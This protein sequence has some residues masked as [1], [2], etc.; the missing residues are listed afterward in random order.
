MKQ[1]I[2]ER[3][4]KI[5]NGEVP[6]GYRKTKVGIIPD[7]WTLDNL[8]IHVSSFIVPMR[9]K[10]KIF[11]G[12]IPWC[13]IED[14]QGKYLEKSLSNQN[15]SKETIDEMN[16]RV[17]P[18]GTVLCSCSARLGI[19][20]IVRKPL[21]TN[22]T[23]IG[24]VP[25]EE[26]DNEFLYYFMGFKCEKLQ[27][28]SSG[29]TISYLSRE[30]FEN[31]PITYTTLKEQKKIIS[32]IS[33]W[34][35]AIELKEKLIEEKKE[36]KKGLMQKLLTGKIR[37]PEFTDEWM[38]IDL[39][40]IV[41]KINNKNDEKNQTIVT[42]SAKKGFVNQ[43]EYFNKI[44]ASQDLS[45]YYLIRK[46]DFAYN[47]SYSNGYPVGV[48][49]RLE[50]FEKA[51][52]TTLY[53]CFRIKNQTVSSNFLKY[54]FDSVLLN[55][56][57]KRIANEGGRAHGL[58]NVTPSDFFNIEIKIPDIYEQEKIADVLMSQDK[59][60]HLMELTLEQL[61]E[62]KRGLMQLLLTGIVRVEVD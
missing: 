39:N 55:R 42:I 37:F 2:K 5:H 17:Y 41:K 47:K 56:Q 46:G 26:L 6:E 28:L 25:K 50:S 32:I 38:E 30:E 27:K 52:V 60:I 29:T 33:T 4:E 57:I 13:R 53:I 7:D 49:K 23:F 59:K 18:K 31:F 12:D 15:V 51:V 44:V 20:T 21:V 54:Y 16:L 48:I 3:V 45:N 58:L 8:K 24:L 1:E 14:F 61:K 22:Q 9:D 40:K 36:F 11:S 62:Q 10:P 34:D 19:C 43:N 35:K